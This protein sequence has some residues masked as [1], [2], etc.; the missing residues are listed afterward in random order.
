MCETSVFPLMVGSVILHYRIIEK[1]GGGGM[2]VVYKAEDTRLK[3]FVALKFLRPEAEPTPAAVERL[4]REAEAASALNHPNICTIH[5]IG[6]EGGEQ[7]IVMEFLDGRSLKHY[8]EGKP[9]PVEEIVELAVQIADA[10]DAAHGEGI[11]HRDI[12][13]ANIFITKR[14]QAK[15]L[16]F[17]LAKLIPTMVAE[18]VGGSA[19][20]TLSEQEMLTRPGSTIGTVAYMSPEQVRGE[21]LDCRTD[22]FSFGLV[23]YEMA[24]GKMA[25]Q[26]QTSGII[27]EGILNRP[28][29]P[30]SELTPDLPPQLEAI[31]AKAIQKDRKLRYQTAGEMLSD[32]KQLRRQVVSSIAS[33]SQV[34]G[35]LMPPAKTWTQS[36]YLKWALAAAALGVIAGIGLLV[37]QRFMVHPVGQRE[38]L[39]VLIADFTNNTSE[40]VFDGTI[41]P[42]FGLALEGA[43]FINGYSREQ[44]RKVAAQLQ[45]GAKK[46]DESLARLVATRE[47]VHA[48][49]N[50]TISKKGGQYEVQ[51]RTIDPFTGKILVS[52][53]STSG[54]KDVLMAVAKLAA[55]VRAALGDV[56]PESVQL[57][58]AETFTSGSLEAAHEYAVAQSFHWAGKPDE[59]IQHYSKAAQLDPDLGRAY[60]GLAV[61]YANS[62]Q[63][64][65]AEKYFM[66][67]LSKIDHMSDREKYRIRGGYYLFSRNPSKALE[68]FT[69]LV[70][71]YPSD[72]AGVANEA[73]AYF[74][75]R[76]MPRALQEG[77]HAVAL[78]PKNVIQRNNAALYAMYAGD[79]VYAI[80][81][82][83]T[84]LDMNS[85]YLRAHVGL[86]L[87]QLAEGQA[88][89]SRATYEGLAKLNPRGTSLGSI[90]LAD[91]ALYQG[92]PLDAIAILQQGIASD[93][94]NAYLDNAT[95]KLVTLAEADL[96]AGRNDG[97]LAS[98]DK[99][100]TTGKEEDSVKFLAAQVYLKAGRP[101]KALA[102]ANQLAASVQADPRA[103]A[104]LIEGELELQRGKARD[105]VLRLQEANK[106]ADTWM[107]RFDLGRADIA[108]DAFAEADSELETCLKR[109]GEATALFLDEVPTYRV[110]PAVYYYLGRAQEG[111]KSPAASDS[112]QK[113][114][115]FRDGDDHDPLVADA[116]QRLTA[117]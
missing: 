82:F 45:P 55:R 98:A 93:I 95:Q 106:L 46:L 66:L 79:F 108:T 85:S 35:A 102:L 41:E 40:P 94:Q 91:L 64:Q 111:L 18:S 33:V 74:Y 52:T 20:P 101:Q 69:Q 75:L 65:Q 68:E 88:A 24:T 34:T 15:V 10:L 60:S 80:P 22:V 26:G 57:A 96:L 11:V 32:L 99:A 49:V 77:R 86:A 38:P 116:R 67:A 81:E 47:N 115:S 1:L 92:H 54:K 23:L 117:H 44:A 28:P 105:A 61:M 16:D 90:G 72:T 37:R 8:I 107:G 114:L 12:K 84:V 27:M 29:T 112:Y 51:I 17:G 78:S 6:E 56:V 62:G 63:S 43:S 113:F 53:D 59:A 39:S 71:R 7:F 89:E 2:G 5:D 3:R 42:A 87:S 4:K 21:Q 73:L 25:F 19:T 31:I 109:R 70:Q 50:G 36:P 100:L 30:A 76:D 97:A 13:P 104:K 9:L 83:K 110:F 14:G 103:Y 58:Q 48:V